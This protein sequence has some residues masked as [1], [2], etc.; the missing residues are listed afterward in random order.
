MGDST[1]FWQ[2]RQ[3]VWLTLF[4][5]VCVSASDHAHALQIT[6]AENLAPNDSNTELPGTPAVTSDASRYLVVSCRTDGVP[7]GLFG[8]FVEFDG[9]TSSEFAIA[10]HNCQSPA[11]NLVFDGTST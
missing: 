7:S 1:S 5:F 6:L 3:L 9:A 2:L 10:P 4:A 11:P 8:V